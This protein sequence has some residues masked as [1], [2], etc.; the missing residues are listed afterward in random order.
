MDFILS[1]A[2]LIEMS[3]CSYNLRSISSSATA[4]IKVLCSEQWKDRNL[5]CALYPFLSFQL[6]TLSRF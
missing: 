5:N 1:R 2:K 3:I 6:L 4:V